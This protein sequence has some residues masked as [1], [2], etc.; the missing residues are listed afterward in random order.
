MP[1]FGHVGKYTNTFDDVIGSAIQTEREDMFGEM[2]GEV[3][4]FDPASQTISVQPLYRKRLNGVPTDLP[5]L[6]QV[7]VRFPRMGGFVI[8][9]P[10][11]PGDRVT[12]RPQMRNTEAY[13]AGSGA[14]A[15]SDFRSFNL[16]DMEAF[17]DGGESLS[18]PI[19]AF[20]SQNMELRSADGQFAIEMSEDG[21]FRLRG[22]QGD[23][24]ALLAEALRLIGSD[25]LQ[26]AYGSSAGTGHALENATAILAIADKF[27]GM[28]L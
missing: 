8:T 12:L 23:W 2:P 13:H 21:K 11:K 10:V 20:N 16:S 24:F 4:S 22:A 17:L 9:T 1:S 5:V 6:E 28:T 3:M 18:D 25:Q 19:P 26:I 15:A 14:Y 27:D 7:P